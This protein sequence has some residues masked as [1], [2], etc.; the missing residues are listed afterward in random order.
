MT[1]IRSLDILRGERWTPGRVAIHMAH[2]TEPATALPRPRRL[3]RRLW[4]LV[5]W[6]GLMPSG[7]A[8]SAIVALW[9]LRH[10]L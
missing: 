5:A 4:R 6:A 2:A 1:T 10:G 8:L 3:P 7:M 9:L